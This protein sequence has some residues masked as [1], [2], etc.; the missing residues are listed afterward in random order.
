MTGWDDTFQTPRISLLQPELRPD[1]LDKQPERSAERLVLDAYGNVVR[2]WAD[3]APGIPGGRLEGKFEVT[4]ATRQPVCELSVQTQVIR[5]RIEQREEPASRTTADARP[6]PTGTPLRIVPVEDVS[7]PTEEATHTHR[8]PG[9]ETIQPCGPCE[10]NGHLPCSACSQT[11]RVACSSCQGA[12][13]TVCTA[14]N[15]QGR[16]RMAN[17]MIVNCGSC[18]ANGFR[19]CTACDADGQVRCSN[20]SGEGF[21]TCARCAGYGRLCTYFALVS[22]VSTENSRV[23]HRAEPWDVDIDGLCPEMAPLWA[24]DV[25]LDLPANG[26]PAVFDVDGYAAEVSP[27]VLAHVRSALAT[28]LARGNVKGPTAETARAVRLQVRGCYLHRVGYRLDGGT[29]ESQLYIGGL[30]NRVAPGILHERCRTSTAWVQRPFHWLLRSIGIVESAGPSSKFRKRLQNAGGAVHM[31][32]AKAVV[33]E[34]IEVR[35]FGLSVLD[36][37]YEVCVDGA[38]I[39]IIELTHDEARGD[40]IVSFVCPLGRAEHDRFID[41]LQFNA[42]VAFGR[43]GL[44]VDPDS[45]A[46]G[47]TLFDIRPYAEL[48]TATYGA[49]LD[50]LLN[51][52]RPK[53][54]SRLID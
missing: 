50:Y 30:R 28:A 54:I 4:S 43:V 34:A 8:L 2:L 3:A 13:R 39:A 15:G 1:E 26:Q 32:D 25:P 11:G 33:A 35:K 27:G 42:L 46:L 5:R 7:F 9:G 19:V 6:L 17:G 53:A 36:E 51:T 20:C 29:T 18:L 14:C 24:E 22:Q 16:Q 12:K 48:D 41:A 47:F 37:G 49:M 21:I 23:T 52:V 10:A 31:L 40:L 44:V 38:R 45:G